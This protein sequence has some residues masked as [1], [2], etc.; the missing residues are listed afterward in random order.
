MSVYTAEV[1]W[2]RDGQ[3]FTGNR[4]SRR[5][6]L[7]FDGG[8]EVPGSSS[9]HVVPLPMSDASAVDPEEM[10]IASLSSCH[11]LWF[12]SLAAKQRFVVDRYV[13]AATGVMEKNREGQM[14][15]TVVTLRP[16]V[17]FS[18]EREPTRD[19]LERLHHAAHDACFIASSVRTEVRCEPVLAG[20]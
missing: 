10:F 13:D 18:G 19:E 6:V 14:A 2:Q 11:M 1:L 5:H 16:Q 20:A 8:A 4:Y 7:R 9:P 15:M 3:D 12:L 17:T